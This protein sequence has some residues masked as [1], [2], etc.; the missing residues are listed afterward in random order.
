MSAAMLLFVGTYTEQI[1]FGSGRAF[2]GGGRGI[3]ILRLDPQTGTLAAAGAVEGVRNPSFLAF[4]PT[5]RFLYAVNELKTFDGGFGGSVSAFSIARDTG[6]LIPL[7]TMATHGTDPCHLTVD[8]TGR[9]LLVA[10]YGSGQVTVLPIRADGS[11]APACQVV[12]HVGSSVHPVRQTGPHAHCVAVDDTGTFV[13][14]AD[15]GMDRIVIY[16]LDPA[17]GMLVPHDPPFVAASPGVGPRQI[18]L[19]PDIGAAYA[20]NE[21]ASSVTIYAYDA[22]AGQLAVRRTLSTLPADFQ[23]SNS[24]AELQIAPS[25]RFLYASNRGHDSVAI[26]RIALGSSGDLTPVGH[27]A[28]GG[29]TPRHFAISADGNFLAAANQGSGTVVLF[30]VDAATGALSPTDSVV[31]VPAPVCVRFL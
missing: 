19:H 23:G 2:Q 21:I 11:L 5:R 16:R 17:R 25:G 24:C 22:R 18:V 27:A 9:Y 3:H 12:Q 8:R 10:N 26:F 15:L 6:D 14:V 29:A 30:R 4:D 13:F 28:T 31:E 1:L 7:N 20:I